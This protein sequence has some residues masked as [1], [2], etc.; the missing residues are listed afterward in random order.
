VAGDTRTNVAVVEPDGTTT[1]LN[2][3][4]P[5]LTEADVAALIEAC[6]AAATHGPTRASWVV[7]SGSLPPGTDPDL[8]ARLVRRLRPLGVRVAVDTS[9]EPL[10]RAVA[11]APDL[12]KPNVEELAE[13]AGPLRTLGDVVAAAGALRAGGVTSVLVSLGAQGLLLADDTG[14]WHARGPRVVVRSTVGAGDCALA[15]FVAAPASTVGGH[16]AALRS[17]AAFGAAAVTQPGTGVPGPTN[18][19]ARE[20][21]VAEPDV[22]L[23]LVG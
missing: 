13:L 12:V 18:L 2:E 21:V 11:A 3:P 9:G 19:R 1:K 8:Y 16:R 20:V 6:V 14:V 10:R 4:G 23:R 17:A 22:D 7:A 15:G 5:P